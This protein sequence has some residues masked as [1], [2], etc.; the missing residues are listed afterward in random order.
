MLRGAATVNRN[1]ITSAV[2]NL[3]RTSSCCN[4]KRL[5]WFMFGLA[6]VGSRNGL[7]EILMWPVLR[8]AFHPPLP[9]HESQVM[10]F[11]GVW[12][13][14]SIER[15]DVR[16]DEA[17]IG[18]GKLKGDICWFLLLRACEGS[19]WA[20]AGDLTSPSRCHG[21][22]FWGYLLWLWRFFCPP[23]ANLHSKGSEG[24]AQ[25]GKE[26]KMMFGDLHLVT[27][28]RDLSPSPPLCISFQPPSHL[29]L[30]ISSSTLPPPPNGAL[31]Q[32]SR[33]N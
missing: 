19:A 12:R 24:A 2:N 6:V 20:P 1:P 4:G 21:L 29:Y 11:A 23:S 18:Q 5:I 15:E 8:P 26:N 13:K 27:H 22:P 9:P 30:S 10:T 28:H 7:K 14:N 33:H 31:R 17:T 16:M 32:N 25:K 3:F